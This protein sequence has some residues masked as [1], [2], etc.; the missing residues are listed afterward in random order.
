VKHG[1]LCDL[2]DM[3]ATFLK[4]FWSDDWTRVG[5]KMQGQKTRVSCVDHR[6]L[7]PHNVFPV[8]PSGLSI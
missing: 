8:S 7:L 4:M 3:V 5:H 2:L 6:A 1:R